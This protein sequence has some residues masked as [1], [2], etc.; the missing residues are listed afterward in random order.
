MRA[1]ITGTMFSML[2]AWKI[3]IFGMK[4]VAWRGICAEIVGES[5]ALA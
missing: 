5:A 2:F 3:R 4:L 1:A